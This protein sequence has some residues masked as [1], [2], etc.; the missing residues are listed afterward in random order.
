MPARRVSLPQL[1]TVELEV[2]A[3][4]SEERDGFLALQRLAMVRRENG[5]AFRYDL[6]T[7]RAMDAAVIVAHFERDGATHV[8]LRSSI[9]PP[10][11]LRHGPT[12][13]VLWELPAGLI[14]PGE[15]AVEGAAREL[16][17]ELG[18]TVPVEALQP[19][20]PWAAPAP[21]VIAEVHHFFHVAVDPSRRL[22]PAGDGSP[23][24]Q[25]ALVVTVALAE[26]LVYARRGL[27][28]DAKTELALRRLADE[29]A[30]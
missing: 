5:A 16:E 6:V 30:S 27:L 23:L 22:P 18:F 25:G 1:P 14:E 8:Y 12:A 21:A 11:S 26:A 3:D 15:S 19:L 28:P 24:E 9:R 29:L 7:R 10:L 17:E 20:G 13:G 4:H 2:T